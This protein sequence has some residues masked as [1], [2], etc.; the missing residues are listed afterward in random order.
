MENGCA[1]IWVFV[2]NIVFQKLNEKAWIIFCGNCRGKSKLVYNDSKL[3]MQ[4]N[5]L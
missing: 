4:F 2:K 1:S 3:L 5:L